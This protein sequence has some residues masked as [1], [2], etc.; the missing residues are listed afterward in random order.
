MKV[1]IGT[2]ENQL[3]EYKYPSDCDCRILDR[4]MDICIRWLRHPTLKLSRHFLFIALLQYFCQRNKKQFVYGRLLYWML[5]IF[6]T[7]N[8][9][10]DGGLQ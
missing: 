9:P 1:E 4:L 10:S 3:E 8:Q 7:I 2:L 5:G 6:E